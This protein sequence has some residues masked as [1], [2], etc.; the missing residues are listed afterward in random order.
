VWSTRKSGSVSPVS[1]P[2]L[3]AKPGT[4]GFGSAEAYQRFRPAYPEMIFERLM[5]A[6]GTRARWAADLG[7]G[8]GQATVPLL[9]RFDRVT[10]IEPDVS[11]AGRLPIDTRL[12]VRRQNAEDMV[13]AD[14]SLD[15]V[16]AANAL[17][18]MDAEKVVQNSA[19]ALRPGGVFLAFSTGPARISLSRSGEAA[20]ARRRGAW[21]AFQDDKLTNCAGY[22]GVLKSCSGFRTVDTF[23]V[24]ADYHWSAEE[25]AGFLLSVSPAAAWLAHEN[26]PEAARADL[27]RDMVDGASG[28]PIDVQ[29]H[30]EATLA[31]A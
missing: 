2:G 10:A 3:L 31:A 7:A 17:H 12:E 8:T 21:R 23:Y 5:L 15:A 6:L 27:T 29:I 30:I 28:R 25:A 24:R 20:L 11:M 13:F 1:E 14:R 16:V 26:D 4:P 22:E 18:W 19:R 9:Q